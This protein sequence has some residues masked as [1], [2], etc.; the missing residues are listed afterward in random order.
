MVP[1]TSTAWRRHYQQS[2]SIEP[3]IP[4]HLGATLSATERRV[5]AD[6]VR[7]FQLGES[8]E[9]RNLIVAA[10]AYAERTGDHE[11]V[12]AI[13]AFI[14]EEQRHARYL[15]RFLATEGIPL[16]R[17]S[18]ADSVFRRLRRGAELEVT[19]SVLLTAEII[20]QVYYEALSHA[21]GSP[22]LRAICQRILADE[23]EHV[24][25]QAERLAILRSGKRASHIRTACALQRLLF[26]AA[27]LVVWYKHAQVLQ[28]GGMP[29]RIY[30]R[31]CWVAFTAAYEKMRPE[32]YAVSGVENDKRYSHVSAPAGS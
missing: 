9:G 19:I 8:S 15:G 21:T 5:I 13:E 27:M 1:I 31:S 17:H 25:F 23:A 6:S 20:A 28:Q 24:R 29:W 4:W 11:Y 16:A 30:W 10:K 14:R 22:V 12:P 3:P 7:E 26:G 32:R 18:W 2:A